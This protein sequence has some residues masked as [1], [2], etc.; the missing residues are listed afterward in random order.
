MNQFAILLGLTSA[1]F[2][3]LANLLAKN[4]MGFSSA[5]NFISVT[6]G[7]I[8]IFLLPFTPFFFVINL[9]PFSLLI[10]FIATV[11]DT[12]GNYFYFTTFEISDVNTATAF[13]ALSPLFTLLALPLANTWLHVHLTT[14]N[15]VGAAIII[16]GILILSAN[17]SRFSKSQ[18][19]ARK[20]NLRQ[21]ILPITSSLLFGSNV[22]LVKYIFTE[23][24]TTPFSYYFIRAIIISLISALVFRPNLSWV[25]KPRLLVTSGRVIIVIIQGL[26][27]YYALSLGN[28]AI[29]KAASETTPLF[30]LLISIIFLKESFSFK[31][32]TGALM[33]VAG[34]ILVSFTS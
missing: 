3:A 23:Q 19:T 18:S 33:I 22:I 17:L 31:K 25:T 9:A 12:A 27:S 34:L 14:T 24:F 6:F 16:I 21:I 4:V 1:I 26:L 29:T 13:L 32:A 28:P 11:I 15:M 5:R 8:A 7:L 20:L 10:I 30:V 2:Y